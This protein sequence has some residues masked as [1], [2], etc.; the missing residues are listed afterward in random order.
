[1]SPISDPGSL[2]IWQDRFQQFRE[3]QQ[4]IAQFCQSVGC[5]VATFYYWKRKVEPA[6]LG[7]GATDVLVKPSAFVPVVVRGSGS[8]CIRIRLKEGAWVAVPVD[9]LAALEVVLRHAQRVA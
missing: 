2:Q 8:Q 9:A 5:S 3:N 1:M 6:A 7:A 4:T